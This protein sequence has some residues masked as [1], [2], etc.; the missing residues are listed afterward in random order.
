MPAFH[1]GRPDTAPRAQD[2]QHRRVTMANLMPHLI[3]MVFDQE[4]R[5]G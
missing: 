3:R 2:I 4:G 5:N 1:H